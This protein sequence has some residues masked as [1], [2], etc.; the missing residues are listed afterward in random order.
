ML[1]VEH[2]TERRPQAYD[3]AAVLPEH[4]KKCID[5]VVGI[6]PYFSIAVGYAIESKRTYQL[7]MRYMKR[8]SNSKFHKV[9]KVPQN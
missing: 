5:I 6:N 2:H 8:Q 3:R 7:C 4:I 1:A 9:P